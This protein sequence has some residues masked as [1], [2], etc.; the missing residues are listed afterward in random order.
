VHGEVGGEVFGEY[1]RCFSTQ[2]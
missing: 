2:Q 1:V